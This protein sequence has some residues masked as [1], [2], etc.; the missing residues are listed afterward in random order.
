MRGIV[1]GIVFGI[2]LLLGCQ[3]AFAQCRPGEGRCARGTPM[4][5]LKIPQLGDPVF[6]PPTVG[7]PG[8]TLPAG[9]PEG[10]ADLQ[11]R[12]L[13]NYAWREFECSVKWDQRCEDDVVIDLEA[14][15]EYCVHYAR[16]DEWN[17]AR[18][19]VNVLNSRKV[20]LHFFTAGSNEFWNR[21]GGNIKGTLIVGTVP[22]GQVTSHR[23][24]P[25]RRWSTYCHGTNLGQCLYESKCADLRPVDFVRDRH[26]VNTEN[27][28]V[29]F[30][31]GI[32]G[33]TPNPLEDRRVR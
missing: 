1:A 4:G 18:F 28:Q 8:V 14:N 32:P 27:Y 30:T 31:P 29:P 6:P 24:L 17:S 12:Y 5:P 15:E 13:P 19:Q 26:C 7:T 16:I 10:I 11:G 3:H 9:L 25:P 23:C 20:V 22:P 21:T 33:S 2:G